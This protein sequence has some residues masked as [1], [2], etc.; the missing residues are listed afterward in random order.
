MKFALKPILIGTAAGLA[1]GLALLYLVASAAFGPSES[2]YFARVLFPYATAV[3]LTARA[4]VVLSLFL[5][6]YPLYGALLGITSNQ[7]RH[8]MLILVAILTLI[9]GGH[10]A[11][12]RSAHRADAIWVESQA[13]E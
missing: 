12:V 3:N 8:R 7:V 13:W 9:V 5:L 11:A 1:L 6:Q 10:L 4:W 2:A